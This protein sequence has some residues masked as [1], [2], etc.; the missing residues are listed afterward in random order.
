M[1]APVI[2]S[3][4]SI[5][6]ASTPELL[7]M[8]VAATGGG[9]ISYVYEWQESVNGTDWNNLGEYNTTFQS[10]Y[11]TNSSYYRLS[12]ISSFDCGPIYSEPVYIEVYAV[13]ESGE[14]SSSQN[15]CYGTAPSELSF[16]I[17]SSG[18]DGNYTYLWEESTDGLNYGA[19]TQSNTTTTYQAESLVET[20]HYR[21]QISS[22][23]G[24]GTETT[25]AVTINVYAPLTPGLIGNSQDI[26]YDSAPL[27][28]SLIL[29]AIGADGN[30]SY[31]WEESLD[32]LNF[33]TATQFNTNTSYQAEQLI[34]SNYYRL[35]ISSDY[36]CGTVYTNVV[37]DSVY[38]EMTAPVISSS[39]SICYASTP[40]LLTMD[41]AATGGGDFSYFYEWQKSL[42]GS[43]WN[44]LGVYGPAI[45]PA[46]LT[47]STYYRL[48][49]IS[50]FVCGP[51]Y[52]DPVYIEVY[53]PLES[54]VINSSQDICYGTVSDELNFEVGPTGADGDYTYLWEQSLNGFDYSDANMYNASINYQ[55]E[56]LFE[57]FY[58]RVQVTSNYGCGTE[59][60]TPVFVNVYDEF[61][62]GEI[63]PIETICFGEV[64]NGI[65]MNDSPS[66]AG[67]DFSYQWFASTNGNGFSIISGETSINHY[68][69]A[70]FDTTYYKLMINSNLGCGSLETNVC[71]VIVNSLPNE[72]EIIG[73]QSVCANLTDVNYSLD[74]LNDNIYYNWSTDIGDFIG[75]SETSECNIHF[76]GFPTNGELQLLQTNT[77]TGCELQSVLD[78]EITDEYAPDKS[79]IIQKNNSNILICSDSSAFI[80]Y[81][82]GYTDIASGAASIYLEDTL[83]YIQLEN[84]I[85]TTIY[86]Y[87]VDTNWDDINCLTRS[88]FNPP[89][90]LLEIIEDDL[91]ESVIYPNP[92]SGTLYFDVMDAIAVNVY[93]SL[94][95]EIYPFINRISGYIKFDNAPPGIYFIEIRTKDSVLIEKIILR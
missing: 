18:A 52:S 64:P 24:C 66:G 47:T 57:S 29:P 73:D 81:Q 34:E 22:V 60:T 59:V 69:N 7:T 61:I 92:S 75:S 8:D 20:T 6:Y 10:G 35:E 91:A 87:W 14:I 13:L 11:L 79:L 93:S 43:S 33:T 85:D 1:T 28:H 77:L 67:F 71:E 46:N 36:G 50:S 19:S 89:D 27:A 42:N 95:Q 86:R 55:S 70:L 68:P 90:E 4:Q 41:I 65:Q 63:T 32:S 45:Q 62:T 23:Y 21:V 56:F 31:V 84:G 16:D 37:K 76:E 25:S 51:I 5:C 26:C 40:D 82:W 30:Y 58:Y 17:A 88:Y 44:G 9:D 74:V 12:A 49:A 83:Q 72:I 94:G 78:I 80:N 48:S 53:T 54:G 15:I 39:Q 2:S 3:S 38:N